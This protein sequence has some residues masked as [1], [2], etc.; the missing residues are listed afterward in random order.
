MTVGDRQENKR[1]A[2][3]VCTR[4]S[5]AERRFRRSLFYWLVHVFFSHIENDAH[6]VLNQ[7]FD[8]LQERHT[9]PAVNEAVIVRQR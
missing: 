8:S 5:R 2:N 9:F 7:R 4:R 6:W 1:V 3:R